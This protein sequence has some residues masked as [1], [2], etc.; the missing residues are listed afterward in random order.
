MYSLQDQNA[1]AEV[2]SNKVG[3]V[4]MSPQDQRALRR[5]QRKNIPESQPPV[6]NTDKSTAQQP[7]NN[8]DSAR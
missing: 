3:G 8:D 4:E 6:N 7:K 5:A 1:R 2:L